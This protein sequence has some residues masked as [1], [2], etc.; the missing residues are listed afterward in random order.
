MDERAA[1]EQLQ[2]VGERIIAGVERCLPGWADAHVR[3]LLDEW[4]R[5]NAATRERALVDVAAAGA[6]ATTEVVGELRALL[7]TDPTEQRRTPLEVVRR[8]VR[9]PTGVLEAAGVPPVVRDAFDERAFPDDHYDLTPRTLGDLGD[10]ELAPLHLVWGM[11][12]AAVLRSRAERW[13][14]RSP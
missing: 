9:A 8:A 11:A 13:S 5:A 14:R 3:R 7:A 12:K 1:L 4:G 2:E 10:E 6:A